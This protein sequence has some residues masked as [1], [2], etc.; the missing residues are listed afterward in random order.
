VPSVRY[1]EVVGGLH[2]CVCPGKVHG[3]HVPRAADGD[4]KPAVRCSTRLEQRPQIVLE[5]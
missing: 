1:C 3:K 5:L 2:A 4:C